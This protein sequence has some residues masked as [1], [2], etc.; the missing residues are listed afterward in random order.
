MEKLRAALEG[1]IDV[2][3]RVVRYRVRHDGRDLAKEAAVRS[4]NDLRCKIRNRLIARADEGFQRLAETILHFVGDLIRF[5]ICPAARQRFVRN[6]HRFAVLVRNDRQVRNVHHG[7]VAGKIAIDIDQNVL[8]RCVGIHDGRLREEA[9]VGS[10]NDL[11][12]EARNGDVFDAEHAFERFLKDRAK[13]VRHRG[14]FRVRPAAGD[15]AADRFVCFFMDLKRFARFD[16]HTRA[17]DARGDH[18]NAKDHGNGFFHGFLPPCFSLWPHYTSPIVTELSHT[19]KNLSP[20]FIAQTTS[21][22]SSSVRRLCP[23]TGAREA[24]DSCASCP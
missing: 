5:R 20:F 3:Q 12:A 24:A 13:P 22:A 2:H 8:R 7:C 16:F 21:G 23:N 4:R 9:V 17:R 14:V 10:R 11:G 19:R 18:Q 1:F 15:R 6:Q